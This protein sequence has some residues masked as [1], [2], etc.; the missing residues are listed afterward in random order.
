[1]AAP[2]ETA[3]E[4]VTAD[5]ETSGELRV[6]FPVLVL[7]GVDTSDGRFIAAGA[8]THRAL[9]LSLLAQTES[10]HGGDEPGPAV[11][12]GRIDRLE[13]RPGPEVVSPSTGEP[14]PEGTFVWS[15]EGVI[16][17]RH[18]VADLVRRGFLRGVSVD[19]VGMNYEVLGEDGPVDEANPQRRLVTH[20]GEIAAATLVPIPA[21]GDAYVELDGE[22]VAP[23]SREEIAEAGLLAS[24]VPAWRSVEVGDVGA[25]QQQQQDAPVAVVD[26]GDDGDVEIIDEA[27]VDL[28]EGELGIP[29]AP[30]PCYYGPEPAVKSLLY[31]G[32][33]GEDEYVPVCSEHESQAREAL[34]DRVTGEVEI[35]Q[36]SE[37]QLTPPDDAMAADEEVDGFAEISLEERRRLAEEGRA[38]PDGSY[39][40]R[41]EEDLRNAIQA[42]GRAKD[43]RRVR[44]HIMRRARELG[45]E[46]LIPEHWRPDGSTRPMSAADAVTAGGPLRP[47]REWFED[48]GLDGPT[49]LHVGEDGR[50]FGHLA[51]WDVPHIGFPGRYVTPP[52]SRS[53]YAYFCTGAIICSDGS[54]VPVGHITLDTGHAD[55]GLSHHAAAAHY[56][57]TGT[58]VADVA[59]GEDDHGIWVAGSLRPGVDE[60]TAAKL[61]ASALSGDWRRIGGHLEL[62][63]ALAV[64]TPGFPVPRARVASGAPLALVAA[65]VIRRDGQRG[66]AQRIDVDALADAIAARLDEREERK[67]L[68]ARAA[69]LLAEIDDTPDRYAELMADLDD[70]GECDECVFAELAELA[71]EVDWDEEAFVSRMPPQLRRS[72]LTGKVAARIRWNTPGDMR[73]CMRQARR[74]GVPQRMIAGMCAML[75]RQATGMWPGDRRNR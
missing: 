52:R 12:V 75:H 14:F 3:V 62:V 5:T 10:A 70:G 15:G 36:A 18:P 38:L 74:H 61:R 31:R 30:Q 32:D 59:A 4:A 54:E 46:E 67:A 68:S 22:P 57:H 17:A 20:A 56:E 6:R 26:R 8:L 21:F 42:V 41:N 27:E 73:R 65:G 66:E 29:E 47:P 1:M 9:P 28:P 72:Y 53:G 50:V 37:E 71:R 34:G 48:P 64:N 40:I 51:A 63:A 19:L 58:V 69:E 45:L 7:E 44:R 13:R 33:D 60:E 2:A 11:V 35:E 43:K 16:D 55:T 24:A 39:P 23:R 25:F 49:A